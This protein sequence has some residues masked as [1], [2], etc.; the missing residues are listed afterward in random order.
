MAITRPPHAFMVR[1]IVNFDTRGMLKIAIAR[2]GLMHSDQ[3]GL[4][5]ILKGIKAVNGN[6]RIEKY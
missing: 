1:F 4:D 5:V 6:M 2:V 3:G